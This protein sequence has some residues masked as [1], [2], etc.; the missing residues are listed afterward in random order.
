M[1]IIFSISDGFFSSDV[2]TMDDD[3]GVRGKCEG[4]VTWMRREKRKI[5][6]ESVVL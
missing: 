6:V 1:K 4:D 3:D 2:F 5:E